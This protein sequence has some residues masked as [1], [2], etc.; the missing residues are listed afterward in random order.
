MRIDYYEFWPIFRIFAQSNHETQMARRLSKKKIS[1]WILLFAT[2]FFI[3]CGGPKKVS[4]AVKDLFAKATTTQINKKKP[5]PQDLIIDK[6]L[7]ARLDSFVEKTNHLGTLGVYVYDETA[8]KEIYA[9]RADTLM[10]PASNMKMLT[11][12]AAI[13]RFGQAYHFT[14]GAYVKG[15]MQQDTLVGDIGLKFTYDPWFTPDS[16]AKLVS[17]F[18]EQNI[19]RVK[20]RIILDLAMTEPM[21]HEEHWTM[22]DLKTRKLGMLYRG[23]QRMSNELKYALRLHGVVF[24]DEQ[25]VVGK[26]PTDAKL[27]KMTSSPMHRSVFK[28]LQNSSNEQ[29]ECLS[30]A[31]AKPFLKDG[32][33]RKA[34]TK[35][36]RHFIRKEL[37]ADP[38]SVSVI[39]DGS[40]LC[41]HDRLTPRFLVRMLHYACG[42]KYIYDE[43]RRTLPIS[44]KTGTLHNR[45]MR[46]EIRG[47]IQAKTGTLTRE[48][49]I[50]SLA[51]FVTGSN[52]HLLLFGIIQN[53]VPV[54]DARL[55]QNKFCEQLVK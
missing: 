39:H 18:Q 45:M 36:L 29:A 30:F 32:D 7:V 48:D 49:G 40:G 54:A 51:G 38:Y 4:S 17:A 52:G 22:G 23:E 47:K 20:G 9:F 19:R 12:L 50:T 25:I 53:E 1:G 46:P 44:A 35:Y 14:N 21:Q 5:N 41:V 31:L 28:A 8:N 42:H 27:V 10:R 26:I 15:E 24:S 11:C 34:A 3:R 13:R 33:Y 2:I 37:N 55:W 16:L 43:L 6:K